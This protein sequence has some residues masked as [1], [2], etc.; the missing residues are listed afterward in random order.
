MSLLLPSQS[1]LCARTKNE[2]RRHGVKIIKHNLQWRT[3]KKEGN[4]GSNI[5]KYEIY[6]RHIPH[7]AQARRL[8]GNALESLLIEHKYPHGAEPFAKE[9]KR[10]KSDKKS[11]AIPSPLAGGPLEASIFI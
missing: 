4:G 1:F 9:T 8:A 2:R 5:R 10:I 3:R 11:A 7:A 6:G